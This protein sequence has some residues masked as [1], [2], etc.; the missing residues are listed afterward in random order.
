M[1]MS[2]PVR[3]IHLSIDTLVLRGVRP[4]D[5][6]AL[7]RGLSEELTRM[8]GQPGVATRLVRDGSP[9]MLRLPRL[10][11]ASAPAA[12]TLGVQVGRAI[13]RGLTR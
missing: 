5:R 3:R 13:G 12:R 8:L 6:H 9:P 10:R 4:E 11:F 1:V 2:T 7:A